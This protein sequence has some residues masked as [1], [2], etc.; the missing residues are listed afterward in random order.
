MGSRKN[1]FT[2]RKKG[3]QGGKT[4]RLSLEKRC[5]CSVGERQR[6]GEWQ[7]SHGNS[8]LCPSNMQE[9]QALRKGRAGN[10]SCNSLVLT[11]IN[12]FGLKNPFLAMTLGPT[13]CDP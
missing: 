5:S 1:R 9:G 11:K 10:C 7:H 13:G 2:P 4:G 12:D 3:R 6:D 8:V